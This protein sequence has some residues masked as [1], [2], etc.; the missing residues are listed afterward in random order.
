MLFVDVHRDVLKR[1]HDTG[2]ANAADNRRCRRKLF[3]FCYAQ[4]ARG[5]DLMREGKMPLEMCKK[6]LF[7][8]S[9]LDSD[10]L[11]L[12]YYHLNIL[13]RLDYKAAAWYRRFAY[14]IR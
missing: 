7:S 9:S 6:K 10:F 2:V 8:A 1:R 5:E 13:N 12:E 11:L 3:C 14:D 4:C